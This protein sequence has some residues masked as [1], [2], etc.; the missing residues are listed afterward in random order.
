MS[1]QELSERF[2]DMVP[3][4]SVPTMFTI[5]GFG[6]GLYGSRNR[7]A[8][9]GTYVTT[10]AL[11][12]LFIPVFALR[13]Y[14]I[15]D[16]GVNQYY[17]IG[18]EPLSAFA[19]IWNAAL[20]LGVAGLIACIMVSSHINSPEYLAKQKLEQADKL[21]NEGKLLAA[22]NLYRQLLVQGTPQATTA[23]QRLLTIPQGPLQKLNASQATEVLTM[24][25]TMQRDGMLAEMQELPDICLKLIKQHQA[26]DPV[27]AFHLL[28]VVE[29]FHGDPGTYQALKD[30]LLAELT[31]RDPNNLDY[32]VEWAKSLALKQKEEEAEKLL[33]S[34]KD[35][36]GG[37]EGAR[38]L[39]LIYSQTNRL[40][41]A[42]P[43]LKAYA[44]QNLPAYLA[45][46]QALTQASTFVEQT[47]LDELRSKPESDPWV[48]EYDQAATDEDKR[49]LVQQYLIAQLRADASVMQARQSLVNLS[50]VVPA[51]LELGVIT[52]RRGQAM[53]DP[54]A[55]QQALEESEK[56]FLSIRDAAGETTE[57]RVFLGQVYYWM[58]KHDE[59]K[60][61]FDEALEAEQRSSQMLLAVS[62]MLREVGLTEDA[63][64]LAEEAFEKADTEPQRQQAAVRRSLLSLDQQDE[65][66]WLQKT[67]LSIPELKASLAAAQ[68]NQ[69]LIRGDDAKALQH[70][71]EAVEIYNKSTVSAAT[72]NNL[73]LCYFSLFQLT[74][75]PKNFHK[76]VELLEHAYELNPSDSIMLRNLASA[77]L[78]SILLDVCNNA[79]DLSLL[80]GAVTVDR[81][82]YLV[83]TPAQAQALRDK[84]KAHP[85]LAKCLGHFDKVMLLAPKLSDTYESVEKIYSFLQD[86]PH[87]K[88]IS[89][90]VTAAQL[91]YSADLAQSQQFVSGAI[92]EKLK[93]DFAQAI[94]R[95]EKILESTADRQDATRA[96]ALCEMIQLELSR[97][98]FQ[99]PMEID[100]CIRRAEEA[101]RVAP[102]S[103]TTN[104]LLQFLMVRACHTLAKQHAPLQQMLQ[105]CQRS[106]G[107][108]TLLLVYLSRE[109]AAVEE[110]KQDADRQRAVEMALT[111]STTFPVRTGPWDWSLLRHD[112]PA[113]AQSIAEKF[114]QSSLRKLQLQLDSQLS[115]YSLTLALR[116]Q[117]AYEMTGQT[118][119]ADLFQAIQAANLPTP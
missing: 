74:R 119:P 26:E 100:L 21:A 49:A 47:A 105:K 60:T 33:V 70:L 13:A 61:Q 31:R 80:G 56:T 40:D 62:N 36:L 91:D 50:P 35:Q 77:E 78:Q 48:R 43:L 5:N 11:C 112:H 53:T 55:R 8:E 89:D 86:E 10:Y 101:H 37:G 94:Q 108:A 88:Q 110:I 93:T 63:R 85:R 28:Q 75:D 109:P 32:K 117:W 29:R 103:A 113:H 81:L 14:R 34:V 24:L 6:T 76:G 99:P 57:F 69:A 54:V 39:G 19:R 4:Q 46:E 2:P 30:E 3:I 90:R 41:E 87:L 96:V 116:R 52:L 68:G 102:S 115:P 27:G 16:G 66:D 107:E 17:F 106:T 73:A 71:Q 59:G 92:D 25:M 83:Q 67:D 7:D 95:M 82:S 97:G 12:A 44:D 15:A 118:P 22:V 1:E 104:T 45:A 65:I 114:G 79:L 42:Y 38:I 51:V 20:L 58:G 23:Q 111:L 72:R 98:S 64:K 18:R 84:L 9:S